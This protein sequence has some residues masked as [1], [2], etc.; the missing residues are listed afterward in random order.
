MHMYVYHYCGKSCDEFGNLKTSEKNSK[1]VEKCIT[2]KMY[3]DVMMYHHIILPLG[4]WRATFLQAFERG[5]PQVPRSWK[6]HPLEIWISTNALGISTSR[7][8]KLKRTQLV[9]ASFNAAKSWKWTCWGD[10]AGLKRKGWWNRQA[11]CEKPC[12]VKWGRQR[13]R[14]HGESVSRGHQN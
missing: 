4:C 8:P 12:Q 2:K 11:G 10:K 5:G 13:W 9:T 14:I 3:H 1:Q 6:S 7:F